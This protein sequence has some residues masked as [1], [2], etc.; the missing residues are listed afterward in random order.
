MDKESDAPTEE[1][2]GMTLGEAISAAI[3]GATTQR[4]VA[5]H[6]GV[7]DSTVTRWINGAIEPTLQDLA[8][9]EEVAGR[10]RGFII[11]AAG[12]VDDVTTVVEAIEMDPGL[13]ISARDALLNAYRGALLASAEERGRR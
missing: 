3:A 10:P 6:I 11:R 12:Y 9:I 4:A 1:V 7:H 2:V 13:T 8:A 5:Q